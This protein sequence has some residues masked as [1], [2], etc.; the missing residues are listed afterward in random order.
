MKKVA[1]LA[2][3]VQ[4]SILSAFAADPP[5]ECSFCTGV[6]TRFGA[7]APATVPALLQINLEDFTGMSQ[8]LDAQSAEQRAKTAVIIH[9]NVATDKDPLLDVEA[10]TKTIVDWA[11][12][13]GPFDSIGV[14]AT[15][16]NTDVAA[17]AIKRLAVTAQGLNV[18]S[19]II[20]PAHSTDDLTRLYDAGA[21]TYVDAIVADGANVE[22]T[23][24]WVAEKDPAKK[25]YAIVTPSSPNALF[26]A[27]TAFAHGATR[28]YL[29]N[30]TTDEITAIANFNSAFIGDYAYDPTSQTAVLDAKGS[31]TD[32][33]AL[34]F[35]RGEDL[36]TI[37]IPRGD[38][39]ASTI[40]SLPTD[41]YTKPRRVDIAGERDIT[42]V[43]RKGGHFLIGMPPVN[44]PFLLTAEHTEKPE[45]TKEAISVQTQRGITVEE[46]IRTHQAYKSYEESI[47]P[48]YIA[49][50][51]T[52]LRFTLEG[53]EAIEATIAGDYFFD[54]RGAADWIWQNFLIN[55]VKWKYGKIPELPLIQ[56]EKVTQLPLDIHLTNEYR[57]QLVRETDVDGYHTY[58]VRF[59]PPPNAPASL[60]LYRG[61]VWIDSRTWARIRLTMV[62]LHL[63]GEVLSN[64]ERVDFQPFARVSHAP[65]TTAEVDTTDP[66]DILWLPREVGAQQVISAAGR[67]NVVLRATTFSNFRIDPADYD[68]R[69]QIAS[70]SDA[71]IVRETQAGMRYLEK[72]PSGERVVKEGFD[73]SRT[74]ALG[75]IHHDKGLQYA[76]LPLGGIDY[77]N[78]DWRKTGIQT[79]VFFAGLVVAANA[80]KP[81]FAHTRTNVGA[82]LFAIA[83]P[84]TDSMF[85]FGKEQTAEAVKSLPTHL[86]FR[87]GHP[88]LGFGK[89]DVSLGIGH[90]SYSRDSDTAPDFVVPSSTFEITPSFDAQYSR[91]GYTISGF[92]DYT[93]RTSWKPWGVLSEYNPNQKSFTTF[94]GELS[95]S[96]FL[97]KFQRISVEFNYD[98]GQRLDRFS[99][100]QFGFFGS[101]RI[102]GVQSGSVHAEKA[103]LGHLTYGFVFSDQFRIEAFY[104]HA[105]LDDR[106]SGYHHEPFQGVGIAGQ[107]IGPKGTLLRL[108]IGKMVGR[109]AQSGFVANIV[110]LKL[111]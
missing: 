90:L 86:T 67:A 73:T 32:V 82:D 34:T 72:T 105:L 51:T 30:A 104:D 64:E 10:Q 78:F 65:L 42:D 58:E 93:Q 71:R 66:R 107:T 49:L 33:P 57:Y 92:Y 97:P 70:A 110:V 31:K 25:V 76:V 62:Q 5:K 99:K 60:P 98:D 89:A 36:R 75:G 94:G 63:S 52:K 23:V 106:L 14:D 41:R 3:A 8:A 26:D 84:T 28:A 29:T 54:P 24:A 12:Q 74:F 102:H 50:D 1:I 79:N 85:R 95:K 69:H 18:A 48:R 43:G 96:F 38:A 16:P 35:I 44:R 87:A 109:N 91:W 56:P 15:A 111:F 9:Y 80:T 101:Q 46:I 2:V 68:Q 83:I 19:R 103:M 17:Y 53:G 59:E 39:A 37:I 6:V 27:A 77:F 61:T 47:Q 7:P 88:F 20:L 40:A 45:V 21:M 55:G 4:L 13:H 22:K 100:Y 81:D 11:R 108:D